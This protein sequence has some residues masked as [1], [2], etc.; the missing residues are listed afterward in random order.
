M[1]GFQKKARPI[2]LI[3]ASAVLVFATILTL[4][5]ILGS[6]PKKPPTI[7]VDDYS[8]AIDKLE[9]EVRKTMKKYKIPSVVAAIVTEDEVIY[10]NAWGYADKDKKTPASL[11]TI[12]K[13]GS[14]S[15][16]L[17]ALEI[18]HM[19]E[20]G[21]ININNPLTDYLPE[22]TIL[23]DTGSQNP[24]IVKDILCH[25]SGLPRNSRYLLW[26][27]DTRPYVLKEQSLTLADTYMAYPPGYKYKYSNIGYNI[28]GWLIEEAYDLKPPSELTVGAFP[29]HMEENLLSHLGM[30]DSSFGTS[31]LLYGRSPSKPVA[32][33][34]YRQ[35]G[36]NIEHNQFDIISLA[37]GSFQSTMQD[38]I[39]FTQAMLR[40]SDGYI[41]KSTLESMY[42]SQSTG[43][44]DPK[45]NGLGWMI[46]DEILG[47]QVVFH[48]GTNQGFISM[49]AFIPEDD[50][51]IVIYANSDE[52][53]NVKSVLTFETLSNMLEARTGN[54]IP[55]V[56]EKEYMSVDPDILNSY[57]GTYIMNDDTT[58]I[59]LKNENLFINY[60]GQKVKM[61]AVSNNTFMVK[62]WLLD[63]EIEISFFPEN[64]YEMDV[65]IV[66]MGECLICPRY[67][68]KNTLPPEWEKYIGEYTILPYIPSTY[69]EA[70]SM[71][72][73]EIKFT[74]GLMHTSSGKYLIPS[75]DGNI[76]ICGGVFDGE[77][78]TYDSSAG[79]ISWQNCI[80]EPIK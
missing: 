20:S 42:Q 55:A 53:E 68:Q 18:M 49:M 61:N 54:P 21:V 5:L 66:K 44:R 71:G 41:S 43:L 12:Y 25:R 51:G 27:W 80:Y 4:F 13:M 1:A 14:I 32:T 46:E 35:N 60:K 64:E 7:Q 24:I 72:T 59:I 19:H 22:F 38:M 31:M 40:D 3:V 75:E 9:F 37:S 26:G 70:G 76:L 29:Y 56:T 52:F 2:L 63:F 48:D 33:G 15:K 57:T 16:A 65:M 47:K 77:K 74:N 67:P 30:D 23:N 34:Y 73:M 69:G 28:L 36:K 79:T 17:V 58:D 78:M 45:P 39:R 62:H 6:G 50:I 11:D 10:S 8:Y